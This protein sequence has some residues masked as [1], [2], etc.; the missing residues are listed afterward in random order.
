MGYFD[1]LA[2][3]AFKTTE[4]GRQLFFPW[5]ILGRGYLI[6]SEE[7]ADRLRRAMD[8]YLKITLLL[9]LPVALAVFTWLGFWSTAI[10]VVA[11]IVPSIFWMRRQCRDLQPSEERVTLSENLAAQARAHSALSLWFLELVSLAF[12]ALGVFLLVADS[13]NWP[14]ALASI[15]FFGLCAAV[16]TT[17]LLI[18]RRESRG[19]GPRL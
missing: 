19:R 15:T 7:E 17:M 4:D 2:S 10:L 1:A 9:V 11:V 18:R 3:G 16:F 8:S 6:P 5:G 13:G 12:V 14:I